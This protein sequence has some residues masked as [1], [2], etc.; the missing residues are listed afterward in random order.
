M[1]IRSLLMLPF[2][3]G[4]WAYEKC[5]LKNTIRW[6]LK[7]TVANFLILTSSSDEGGQFT[8]APRP[9]PLPSWE[10]Q[11]QH[12]RTLPL[13]TVVDADSKT[14]HVSFPF[15][16]YKCFKLS[17]ITKTSSRIFSCI[18]GKFILIN[19]FRRDT[20]NSYLKWI[21]SSY[22]YKFRVIGIIF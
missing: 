11:C 7:A 21:F 2:C 6:N 17:F 14:H 12:R 1:T 15:S 5:I 20:F 22:I 13:Q 18:F 3:L 4:L 9:H 16:S 10:L 8:S 19:F